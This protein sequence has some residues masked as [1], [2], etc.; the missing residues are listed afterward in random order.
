VVPVHSRLIATTAEASIDAAKLGAGVT[1]VLSYQVEDAVRK[2]ELVT[3]LED[4]EPP[5]IP[6]SLVYRGGGMIPLKL[7]AFLDF[8]TPRLRASLSQAKSRSAKPQGRPEEN[9]ADTAPAA[10]TGPRKSRKAADQ[11]A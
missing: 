3:I 4:F 2:G 7:R 11:S 1:R 5:P 6:V 9:E 10:S 8:M